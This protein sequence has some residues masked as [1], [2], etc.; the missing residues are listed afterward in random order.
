MADSNLILGH[1]LS[2]WCGNGPELEEDIALTNIAL[3]LVGQS[4]FLYQE[5]AEGDQTEDDIAYLRDA[6]EFTNL[7]ICEIPNGHYGDTITRQFLYDVYHYYLLEALSN[8]EDPF[9][10]GYARK[11]IKEVSYHLKH[12]ST[13]MLRLGDGTEESH[14]K[15][16]ASLEKIWSYSGEFF[17]F[18]EV[19]QDVFSSLGIDAGQLQKK[20]E[21]K[22]KEV[23]KE[24]TLE[25]PELLWS[26]TGGKTGKH[27]EHLGYILADMQFVRR[28]YPD[29]KVW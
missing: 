4:R 15:V 5:L 21:E 11:S 17:Q 1:R 10:Q 16:Q 12:S 3:D 25:I 18:D 7:L 20:I 22:T 26:Q 23:L 6:H 29:A 24:A 13:W 14:H 19:D 2:E 9:L 27:T 8:C 28:A